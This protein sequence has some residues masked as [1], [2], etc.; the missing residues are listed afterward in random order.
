[1]ELA[2]L[3]GVRNADEHTGLL[4]QPPGRDDKYAASAGGLGEPD[5]MDVDRGDVAVRVVDDP[6]TLVHRCRHRWGVHPIAYAHLAA[7]GP[8]IGVRES[9][10]PRSLY[11]VCGN[12][13]RHGR[14]R[15]DGIEFT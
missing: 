15:D 3:L 4:P 6:S 13:A 8:Q 1:M 2:N 14:R 7:T 9:R 12:D 11:D 5:A 10:R